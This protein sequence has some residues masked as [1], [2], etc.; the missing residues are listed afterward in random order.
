MTIGDA[1]SSPDSLTM[2][3]TDAAPFAPCE[4]V[5]ASVTGKRPARL[6][7]CETEPPLVAD[8]VVHVSGNVHVPLTVSPPSG[9]ENVPVKLTSVPFAIV[10]VVAGTL[11]AA[12]GALFVLPVTVSSHMPRPCVAARRIEPSSVY[13]RS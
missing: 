1:Q 8:C 12:V 7:V 5:A 11:I 4:S 10:C 13:A 6:N 3:S 2:M 9:S